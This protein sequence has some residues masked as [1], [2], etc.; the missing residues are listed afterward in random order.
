ME[1]LCSNSKC[2]KRGVLQDISNFY[3][4]GKK[5]CDSFCKP[6]RLEEKKKIVRFKKLSKLGNAKR[7]KSF[8]D[9]DE[10]CLKEMPGYSFSISKDLK[11]SLSDLMSD[12]VQRK[13]K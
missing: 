3:P 8:L 1:K 9:V 7:R 4:K 10:I 12:M 2:L 13:L 5:Y 11:D 6:C